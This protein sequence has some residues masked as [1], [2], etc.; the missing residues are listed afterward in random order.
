[1]PTKMYSIRDAKAG[2]FHK[3]WHAMSHGDAERQFQK[4]VN[5]PKAENIHDFPEDF[6]LY[7]MG[8]FDEITGNIETLVT[9]EHQVKAIALKNQQ[10][11]LNQ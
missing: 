5:D 10:R 9:P 11:D 6:D 8:T 7:F 4:L 3:P 2:I 1:M